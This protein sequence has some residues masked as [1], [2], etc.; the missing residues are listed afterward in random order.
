[1][2]TPTV[3]ESAAR[4]MRAGWSRQVLKPMRLTSGSSGSFHGILSPQI[5][6]DFLNSGR[7]IRLGRAQFCEYGP[8]RIDI[9]RAPQVGTSADPAPDRGMVSSRRGIAGDV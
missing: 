4:L 1:K 3:D 8:G 9:A 2:T 6:N 5:F 7:F